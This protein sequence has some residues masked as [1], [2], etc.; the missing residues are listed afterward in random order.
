MVDGG[1]EMATVI[2]KGRGKNIKI[3]NFRSSKNHLKKI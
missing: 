3:I 1:K 2:A